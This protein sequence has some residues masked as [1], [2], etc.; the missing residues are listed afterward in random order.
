MSVPDAIGDLGSSETPDG[1]ENAPNREARLNIVLTS[2]ES[3]LVACLNSS[4]TAQA[5]PKWEGRSPAPEVA[6]PRIGRDCYPGIAKGIVILNKVPVSVL[7]S[8]PI[9]PP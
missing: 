1:I 5:E 4:T 7:S 2:L 3:T 9:L 6:F 8:R